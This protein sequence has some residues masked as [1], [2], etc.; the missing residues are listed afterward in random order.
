M[1]SYGGPDIVNEGL[2][3]GYDTGQPIF[4]NNINT[5]LYLG[6]P[7]SNEISGIGMSTYNNVPGS[8]SS[9]LEGTSETFQGAQVIKQTLTPLDSSGVSWLSGGNNP[10]IGVVT[11]GGGGLANRFTGHSIFFKPTV[12]MNG[13][14]IFTSYSNIG[15][16]QSSNLFESVGNGWFRAYVTWYD[17]TTRSDGKY[18][19][20]NPLQAVV[21]QPIVIYWAGPFKED[22]NSQA[23]SP[24]VFSSRSSTDA[25]IDLKRNT[26]LNVSTTSFSSTTNAMFFDGTD[27][28]VGVSDSTS[29]QVADTFTISAWVFPTNLNARYG[30][31]ST[32]TSNTPGCW[33]FEVGTGSG[34]T[35]R[36]LVT[37]VGT[38][39]AESTNN[40][41]TANTW[42]NICF[43]KPNNATQ[44]GTIYVNG[45]PVSLT[46]TTSYTIL[47][48][49]DIKVVGSGTNLSQFFPGNIANV[50]LYNRPL[51]ASEV[52]QNFQAFRPRF[53]I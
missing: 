9:V 7:T 47:N 28:Y 52:Q 43:V 23:V 21:N 31:F 18:W 15:G 45:V 20:I 1:A 33:Q 41:I 11:G 4:S 48:N 53:G 44:G 16:W 5:R 46:Q 37:G 12:P 25:L 13:N 40:V 30:V 36:V 6:R 38:W 51:S 42:S 35:N 26:T 27:D 17:T 24:Y 10:G 22:L 32:R 3:F 34:G 49:S 29:L 19:A 50:C 39:I 2:V 8:V 14:P